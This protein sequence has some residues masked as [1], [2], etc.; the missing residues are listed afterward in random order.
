MHGGEGLQEAMTKFD[1][2]VKSQSIHPIEV[3]IR[4]LAHHS[5]VQEDDGIVIGASK[6]IHVTDITEFIGRGPLPSAL[7]GTV[8]ELWGVVRDTRGDMI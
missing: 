5:A 8:E 3:P 1:A 6:T 7:L 2:E 4:W